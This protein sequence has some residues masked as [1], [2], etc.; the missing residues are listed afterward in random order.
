MSIAQSSN[1]G[2]RPCVTFIRTPVNDLHRLNITTDKITGKC[3]L[4]SDGRSSCNLRDN[5]IINGIQ[6]QQLCLNLLSSGAKLQTAIVSTILSDKSISISESQTETSFHISNGKCRTRVE[7]NILHFIS[8]VLSSRD[9]QW[10]LYSR[11]INSA[12]MNNRCSVCSN[13]ENFTFS[14]MSNRDKVTNLK[15]CSSSVSN[16]ILSVT[17]IYI[18]TSITNLWRI[19]TTNRCICAVDWKSN[20]SMCGKSSINGGIVPGISNLTQWNHPS[21]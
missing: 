2:T 18:D 7:Y 3:N 21:S 5:N 1:S 15:H 12:K 10:S 8:G 20:T 16:V 19:N 13:S 6:M 4:E 14:W 9:R 17:I 11:I